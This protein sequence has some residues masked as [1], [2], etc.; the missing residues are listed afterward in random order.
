MF[1]MT[2]L[3]LGA[4]EPPNKRIEARS[5]GKNLKLKLKALSLCWSIP[6]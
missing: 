5:N 6:G 4:G 3:L 2:R 1:V